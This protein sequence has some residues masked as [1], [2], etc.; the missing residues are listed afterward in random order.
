MGDC[1][2]A[3]TAPAKERGHQVAIRLNT[4]GLHV[5]KFG[6]VYLS[7]K[8]IK[9]YVFIKIDLHIFFICSFFEYIYI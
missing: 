4:V 2:V 3:E 8:N 5:L 9:W 6:Y 7:Y 1:C